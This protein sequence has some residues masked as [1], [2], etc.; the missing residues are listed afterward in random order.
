MSRSFRHTNKCGIT[1]AESE[2]QDK[3]L[4]SR[5]F[6]RVC[7]YLLRL[8]PED[9]TLPERGRDLV[10]PW[11]MAKDGKHTFDAEKWPEGMRK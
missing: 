8:E 5:K 1:K 7:R 2:K 3:Q 10:N 11:S 4:S 6:R 9:H